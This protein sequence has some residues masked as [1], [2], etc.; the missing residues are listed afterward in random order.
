MY[1]IMG[2]HKAWA[3]GDTL[4]ALVKFSPISKGTR[5]PQHHHN[6]HESTRMYARTGWQDNTKVRGAS[7]M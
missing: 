3:V 5:V 6:Y 2:P 7:S 4:T 1:S